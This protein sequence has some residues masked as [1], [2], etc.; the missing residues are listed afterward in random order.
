VTPRRPLVVVA[1]VG[2][3]LLDWPGLV[4]A[5]TAWREAPPQRDAT[6][7]YLAGGGGAADWIRRLDTAHGLGDRPSHRLA[8][9][10]MALNAHVLAALPIGANLASSI[11][12]IANRPEPQTL[13][14]DPVPWLLGPEPP[15]TLAESWDVTSDSIA[16]CLA[17]ALDADTLVL[18]KSAP[19]PPD[20][21]SP[22]KA[23][24]ALLVD[25][26]FPAAARGLPR[27]EWVHL[28]NGPEA[29]SLALPGSDRPA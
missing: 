28:R 27:V 8:I 9:R 4:P 18:H 6:V 17:H 23:A 13:V 2:G 26:A 25:L 22:E 21:D 29:R 15:T 11:R 7:V 5:L 10:A 3:S 12:P 1:K 20:C 14:L 19:L 16:A 24:A